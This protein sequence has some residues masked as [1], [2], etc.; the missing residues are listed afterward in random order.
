M[1]GTTRK[2]ESCR[3]RPVRIKIAKFISKNVTKTTYFNVHKK[4]RRALAKVII[5]L[6]LNYWKQDRENDCVHENL[7]V[8]IK[9]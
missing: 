4:G 6:S 3:N 5:E 2:E 1:K 8:K 9:Y 7:T